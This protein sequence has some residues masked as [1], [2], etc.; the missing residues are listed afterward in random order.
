MST[1]NDP[2]AVA[3]STLIDDLWTQFHHVWGLHRAGEYDKRAWGE[4][5]TRLQAALRRGG[6]D[7]RR[8]RPD[9]KPF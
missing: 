1:D 9:P 5:Q 8:P 3:T 4:L 7:R 2:G 6:L